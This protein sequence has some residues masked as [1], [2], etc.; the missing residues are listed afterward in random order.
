MAKQ[1]NIRPVNFRKDPA[2]DRPKHP[3]KETSK[4]IVPGGKWPHKNWLLCRS[5]GKEK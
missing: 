5:N 4:L 3:K 1:Q 2:R